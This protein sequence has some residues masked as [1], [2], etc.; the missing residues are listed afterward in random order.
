MIAYCICFLSVWLISLSI[1]PSKSIRVI[2]IRVSFPWVIN[3]P[4]F[5]SWGLTI[6]PNLPMERILPKASSLL[7]YPPEGIRSY[8]QSQFKRNFLSALSPGSPFFP[9]ACSDRYTAKGLSSRK[10]ASTEQNAGQVVGGEGVAHNFPEEEKCLQI[11]LRKV[12]F[13]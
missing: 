3:I 6:L 13:S 12:Y 7:L 4:I 1:M 2:T 8:P 11:Y 10:Q 9:A 5:K